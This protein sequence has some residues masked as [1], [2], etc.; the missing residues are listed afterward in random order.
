MK[1]VLFCGGMGLRIC[2]EAGSIPKPMVT[3]GHRPVIWHVMKYYAHYGHKDFIL[4]LGYQ[5]E[6][7]KNYFLN[8]NECISNNF[9][10][11]KGGK[12][13]DLHS[14]D[15]DDWNI[16]FVDTGM[17]TLIGQRLRAIEPYLDGDEMFLAN[18]SDN[19]T[20]F[21]LPKLVDTFL[22]EDR[23]A[24]FL[25]VKPFYSFHIV[26]TNGTNDVYDICSVRDTDIWI[27]GGFF[28]LRK[29]IFDY[30]HD[31]EELVVEPFQRLVGEKKLM[32][33]KHKGFW[34]CMDTFKERQHLEDL[35]EKGKAVWQVWAPQ[36]SGLNFSRVISKI[37]SEREPLHV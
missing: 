11:S 10:L 29:E 9:K 30:I 18:Y 24:G 2:G 14:S 1:V 7:I 23:I 4:C 36:Q 27:N 19:L 33:C 28:V 35:Y 31:G 12:K 6:V 26:S 8:Y 20:D 15:I 13:V 17:N 16:T 5:G 3:I 25:C 21:P 34:A 32:A 22:S 37:K